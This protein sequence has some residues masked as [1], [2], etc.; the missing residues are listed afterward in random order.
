MSLLVIFWHFLYKLLS[1]LFSTVLFSL[2][3]HVSWDCFQ[4][5]GKI[6][7]LSE[8]PFSGSFFFLVQMK[9]PTHSTTCKWGYNKEFVLGDAN[10][11][12]T[13]LDA[14]CSYGSEKQAFGVIALAAGAERRIFLIA[15][16][17]YEG[18]RMAVS[19]IL[20]LSSTV[21]HMSLYWLR[22]L[23]FIPLWTT[24]YLWWGLQFGI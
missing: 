7:I 21:N 11:V 15:L 3:I 8:T 9:N 12:H 22:L 19:W 23:W 14:Q 24:A 4:G 20:L 5:R 13:I 17:V 10:T 2:F 16:F 6:L 1:Y 18:K